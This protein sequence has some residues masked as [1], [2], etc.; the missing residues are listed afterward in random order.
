MEAERGISR[1][2]QGVPQPGRTSQ[3]KS[4]WLE[5]GCV[6]ERPHSGP[7]R[8]RQKQLS[9]PCSRSTDLIVNC[10]MPSGGCTTGTRGTGGF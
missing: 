2:E 9:E 4:R 10:S 8:S 3:L 1:L 6:V 7:Q 5:E